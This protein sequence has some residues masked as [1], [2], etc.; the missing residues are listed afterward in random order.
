[1]IDVI[2]NY[3]TNETFSQVIKIIESNSW[4]HIKKMNPNAEN[5]HQFHFLQEYIEDKDPDFLKKFCNLI[6]SPYLKLKKIKSVAVRR[7]RTNLFIKTLPYNHEGGFHVDY[8]V[9]DEKDFTLLIYLED[10][11]G[12][13][14]FKHQ[15][16]K[17]ISKKNKAIIFP[18]N[19]EHQTIFQTDKLFRYNINVNFKI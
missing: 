13:T 14:E 7:I 17:I 2:D 12:A 8:L 6:L 5:D 11:N 1:M 18:T 9:T 4:R 15:G 19:L 3:F 10:S 16:K